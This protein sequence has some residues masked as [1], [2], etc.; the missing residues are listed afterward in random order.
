MAAVRSHEHSSLG[1]IGDQIAQRGPRP[2]GFT[3]GELAIPNRP[4]VVSETGSHGNS[5]A[6]NDAEVNSQDRPWFLA[7]RRGRMHLATL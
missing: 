4:S 5:D 2:I 6:T 1:L 7:K 3:K